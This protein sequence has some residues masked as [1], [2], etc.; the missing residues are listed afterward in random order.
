MDGDPVNGEPSDPETLTD[1]LMRLCPQYMLMGMTYDEYWNNNTEVHKAVR[2]VYELRQRHEEWARWRSGAYVYAALLCAA[3]A[4]N[5]FSKKHEPG[6]YP[7]E[8]FPITEK[9]S[10]ERDERD[11]KMRFE[12]FM[13][14]LESDSKNESQRE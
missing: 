3:P 10:R 1:V 13:E 9:E 2:K 6:K 5:A 7:R 12:K 8:P 4:M 11:R 14:Q